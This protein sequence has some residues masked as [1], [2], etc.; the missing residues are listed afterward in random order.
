M[1]FVYEKIKNLTSSTKYHTLT[2]AMLCASLMLVPLQSS[3]Q[4]STTKTNQALFSVEILSNLA[5]QA[6]NSGDFPKAIE[7]YTQTIAINPKNAAI[8]Y[9][10]GNAYTSLKN[11]EAAIKDYTQAIA[12]NPKDSLTYVNRGIVQVKINNEK[13]AVDDF[14]RAI[15]I[16]PKEVRAYNNRS[17]TYAILNNMSAAMSDAH[18]ACDMGHCKALEILN[19][20]Q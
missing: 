12:I 5:L 19:K 16:N 17:L 3:S 13:G 18:R 15:A 7:L 10:R 20:N 6:Q 1:A 9:N 11:Y 8:Y 14:T 4:T 2:S